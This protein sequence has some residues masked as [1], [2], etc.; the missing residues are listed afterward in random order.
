[1][2]NKYSAKDGSYVSLKQIKK[3]NSR[4]YYW[5]ILPQGFERNHDGGT[6]YA[7]AL[8]ADTMKQALRISRKYNAPYFERVLRSDLGNWTIREFVNVRFKGMKRDAIW[9]N[10]KEVPSIKITGRI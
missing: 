10:Y 6:T 8:F 9:E 1:M 7:S 5:V 2:K 3:A 4:I